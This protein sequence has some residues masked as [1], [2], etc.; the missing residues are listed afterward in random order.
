MTTTGK[1]IEWLRKKRRW[2]V[3]QLAKESRVGENTI[4]LIE[5]GG[6][7]R[8]STLILIAA[9]LEIPAA[10]LVPWEEAET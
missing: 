6:D 10:L 4:R 3:S 9:A 7:C 2:T 8:L 5:N 1:R